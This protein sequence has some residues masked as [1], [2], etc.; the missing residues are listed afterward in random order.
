MLMSRRPVT[1]PNRPNAGAKRHGEPRGHNPTVVYEMSGPIRWLDPVLDRIVVHVDRANGHAGAF[2]GRDMTFDLSSARVAAPDVDGD[3]VADRADLLPG[4]EVRVRARLPRDL[5]NDP[6]SDARRE[7]R[8]GA[9]RVIV[10]P[11]RSGRPIEMIAWR[12]AWH[13]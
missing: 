3:G 10:A 12:P 6:R 2:L 1:E 9:R 8:G 7:R 13:R 4:V 5:G 11:R